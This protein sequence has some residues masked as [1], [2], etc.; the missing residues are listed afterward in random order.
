MDE[1]FGRDEE[2]DRLTAALDAAR[3]G[4]SAVAVL[5][6]L[7]RERRT[8][9]ARDELRV[10]YELFG[11]MGAQGYAARGAQELSAAGDPAQPGA[12]ARSGGGDLT[13]QEARV[14]RLAAGGATNAEIAAQLYLSVH[15]VDYHL[16]KVFRKLDVHSRRELSDQRDRLTSA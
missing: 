7:R 11:A 2:C 1:L 13:P 4:M 9:E 12:R 14:A 3:R 15:T 10:A 8:K 6:W 5:R 16:R